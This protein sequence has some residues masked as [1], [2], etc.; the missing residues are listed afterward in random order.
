MISLDDFGTDYSNLNYLK[1]TPA[2]VIKLDKSLI[3]GYEDG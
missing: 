2:Q 3:K 1:N